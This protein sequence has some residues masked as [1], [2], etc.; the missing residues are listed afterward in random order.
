MSDT[1]HHHSRGADRTIVAPLPVPL[2]DEVLA[3]AFF[4]HRHRA[5]AERVAEFPFLPTADALAAWFGPDGGAASRR[6]PRRLPRCARP[7]HRRDR[8]ADRRT[9]RRDPAPPADAPLRGTLARRW[10]GWSA[11]VDPAGRVKTESAQHLLGGTLPRSRTRRRVR[12]EPAVPQNLRE[13]IRH[14][15]RRAVRAARDRPRGA[16][17]PDAGR[18]DR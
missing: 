6:R 7:R 15:G 11:G 18:A 2:R 1:R 16:A 5:A 14:A 4:G 3:G 12:P 9:A 13:R 10:R 17:S 8:R